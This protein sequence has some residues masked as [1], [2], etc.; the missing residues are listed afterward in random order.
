MEGCWLDEENGSCVGGK[1]DLADHRKAQVVAEKADCSPLCP[2][3][4]IA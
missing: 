3:S 4:E 1:V 2:K